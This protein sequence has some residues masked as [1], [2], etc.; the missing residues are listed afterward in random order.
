MGDGGHMRKRLI[1]IVLAVTM[2]VGSVSGCGKSADASGNGALGAD[3]VPG[4]EKEEGSAGRGRFMESE[5]T[6]PE[7]V[8]R[9]YAMEQLAD[10]SVKL[11]GSDAN[12]MQFVT[13]QT[14]DLGEHW[15]VQRVAD[16]KLGE[17]GYIESCAIDS[18]GTAV[19]LVGLMDDTEELTNQIGYV[20]TDGVITWQELIPKQSGDE[21]IYMWQC[22][23]DASDNLFCQ[24]NGGNIYKVDR[25]TGECGL[26]CDTE[27]AYSCFFGTAGNLVIVVTSPAGVLLYNAADGS[28]VEDDTVLNE[29]LASGGSSGSFSSGSSGNMPIVFHGGMSEGQMVYACH[30]GIFSYMQGGSVSEQ[31]VNGSLT[32]LGDTTVR[33]ISML[34]PDEDHFLAAISDGNGQYKLL[35]YSYDKDAL[36][37][38]E[39]ELKVY[40]LKDS[41][42]LRQVISSYQHTYQDVYINLQIGMSGEDGVTAEDA[43]RALNTDILAGNGPDV[44]I[45][46]GMP[47]DSYIEKEMLADITPLV[48]EL[49]A[50]DGL[51]ENVVSAYERDGKIYELPARFYLPIVVGEPEAV[52]A[53]ATLS[54]L[55]DYTEALKE[56]G[57]TKILGGAS[58]ERFLE[59]LYAADAGRL[60][61]SDGTVNGEEL[62]AWLAAAKRLYDLESHVDDMVVSYGGASDLSLHGTENSFGILMGECE[63]S[64]GTLTSISM[65]PT[66]LAV[67]HE[68]GATY[69]VVN[70]DS[71]RNFIPYQKVG[72]V[73]GTSQPKEAQNFVRTMLGGECERT[74]GNGFPVNRTAYNGIC[75]DVHKVY[76]DDA[77][78]AVSTDEGISLELSIA[79]PTEEELAAFTAMLESLNMPADTDE[80]IESLIKEQAKSCLLGEKSVEDACAEIEKKVNLYLAE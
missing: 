33:F 35:K 9:I 70:R 38:P 26:Y 32:T 40:A 75:E 49:R 77:G 57:S 63:L 24:N 73:S 72:I 68:A 21:E 27:G 28:R 62:A 53:G 5:V 71:V 79:S 48:E 2:L 12:Q 17:S 64:I 8:E 69:D 41:A 36:S 7:G 65:L 18:D 46:D 74:L 59:T 42:Y 11:F 78:V 56:N 34:M 14:T 10:G 52:E 23:F 67:V 37:M 55:C 22:S 6:L 58:A 30:D 15:E 76:G 54:G 39:K 80:V 19:V 31:L 4:T 61:K 45:L 43:L 25:A 1:G 44:L 20:G 66:L 29:M 51:F 47:V 60:I 50:Q 3:G 13:A 16:D